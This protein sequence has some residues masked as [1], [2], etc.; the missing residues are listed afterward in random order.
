[1]AL[2]VSWLF[3]SLYSQRSKMKPSKKIQL[4]MS[5]AL[6]A[7]TSLFLLSFLKPLRIM[8]LI[9]PT[10]F[11]VFASSCVFSQFVPLALSRFKAMAGTA[12]AGL[13]SGVWLINGLASMLGA[14]MK[15]NSLLGVSVG[16]LVVVT[17]LLLLVSLYY[18]KFQRLESF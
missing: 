12:N 13:F 8:Y 5:V 14:F 4:M 17:I 6:V 7:T 11:I 16:Y 15:T 2:G 18:F 3:G 10:C 1:M 9:S